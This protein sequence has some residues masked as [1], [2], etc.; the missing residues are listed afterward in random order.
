MCKVV[1]HHDHNV[2]VRYTVGM[3]DLVGV[4]HISLGEGE[5]GGGGRRGGGGGRGRRGEVGGGRRGEGGGNQT[6]S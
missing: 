5:E 6:H 3:E 2:V 1:I 4:A